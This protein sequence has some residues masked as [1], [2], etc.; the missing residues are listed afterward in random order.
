MCV[1]AVCVLLVLSE[2]SNFTVAFSACLLYFL[3][4]VRSISVE[5]SNSGN[6]S[7]TSVESRAEQSTHAESGTRDN[8]EGTTRRTIAHRKKQQNGESRQAVGVCRPALTRCNTPHTQQE[9]KDRQTGREKRQDAVKTHSRSTWPVSLQPLHARNT[10]GEDDRD[11]ARSSRNTQKKQT[12]GGKSTA[13]ALT[14]AGNSTPALTHTHTHT[15]RLRLQLNPTANG[16]G[17]SP[18]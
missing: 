5:D 15:H 9:K 8:P 7:D 16:Y 13:T 12:T 14:P 4:C 2:P 17:H 3:A 1:W 6:T 10:G 11:K 18:T